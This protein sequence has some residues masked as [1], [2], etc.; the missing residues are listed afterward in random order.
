MKGEVTSPVRLKLV[1]AA[2][3]P[4]CGLVGRVDVRRDVEEVEEA[5]G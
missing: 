1:D 5:I 2:A 4:P 3:P